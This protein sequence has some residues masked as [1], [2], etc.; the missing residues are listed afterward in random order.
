MP[1]AAGDSLPDVNGTVIA[2]GRPGP[3]NVR[4][5]VGDK[6][7]V[8]FGVPGAF[9][10]TCTNDHL[11]TFAV[12]KAQLDAA[13]I[14]QT[15][16]MSTNDIFVL[17]AWNAAHGAEHITMLADGS[18]DITRAMDIGLDLSGLGLGFRCT[19]FA[20]LVEG[21]VVKA[22]QT[23]ENPGTCAMT[24]AVAILEHA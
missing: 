1:I 24:S 16:C 17:Q 13:G 3:V 21:G 4:E 22:F 11:P 10:P 7:T 14:E 20:M 6:K 19:R 2:D 8:I 18:G 15:I 5:L 12:G 9:T 23:E